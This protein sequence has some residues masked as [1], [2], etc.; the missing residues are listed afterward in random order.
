MCIVFL[1]G[2]PGENGYRGYPGDEGG[3]GDRGPPG[4]NGT[5]GFQGC[6][7]ERGTKGNRGFPG[8]KGELGEIGLDGIDGEE[9]IQVLPERGEALADAVV[10]ESKG[11]EEKEVTTDCEEIQGRQ[12]LITTR[13][14]PEAKRVNSDQ[15]ENAEETDLQAPQEILE[16]LE[17]LAEEDLQESKE[18]EV[19]QDYQELQENRVQ[20]GQRVHLAKLE[21][22]VFGES[23]AFLAQGVLEVYLVLLGSVADLV[24]SV[25]KVNLVTL[26]QR[27]PMVHLGLEER[28]ERMVETESA[29]L[30]L[31]AEGEKLVSQDIPDKGVHLETL[32][33]LV[34]LAPKEAE[35]TGEGQG[36]LVHEAQEER[37]DTQDQ[38][39]K[40]NKG[41]ARDECAL[42]RN[43]KDKC[44]PR[45]CPIYPTE[46]AF[47]IDTSAG[48]RADVFN[49][50][51]QAVLTILNDLTIAESNCPRGAR[52]A[53]VTYNS[54][55]TTEIRFADFRRKKNLVKKIEDLQIQQTSKQRNLEAAMSFV[56]RNTFKRA[57]S[58]FLMRKVAV[59]FTH[60]PATTAASPQLNEAVMKLYDAGVVPVFLTS[61]EDRDLVNALQAQVWGSLAVPQPS[62]KN[63]LPGPTATA[64]N[65]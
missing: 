13:E 52:V 22:L 49:R 4:V 7:G 55:I 17:D 46:L 48:G 56:A 19:Q 53:L 28:R 35:V 15:W 24:L 60:G 10:K 3:P 12:E 30:V 58:G 31:K 62:S 21:H 57:R 38:G 41:E 36:N 61:R 18:T 42:I 40:G 43:I 51:K 34:I 32:V 44:R 65:P 64:K 27:G 16:G 54:E 23:K 50:T 5:Q 29:R 1:K 33:L 39:L 8:E 47:A 45:E 59:F 26:V 6:P 11:K 14:D 25:K 20:E 2:V 63:S 9:D 37:E